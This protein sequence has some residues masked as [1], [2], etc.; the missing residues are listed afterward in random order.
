MGFL[1]Q[2]I[3]LSD[4]IIVTAEKRRGIRGAFAVDKPLTTA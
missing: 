2:F 3:R 4:E 1:E